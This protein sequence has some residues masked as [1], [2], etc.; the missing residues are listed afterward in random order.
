M[1]G[2]GCLVQAVEVCGGRLELVDFLVEKC[3]RYLWWGIPAVVRV[4]GEA[5][6]VLKGD[7]LGSSWE[8]FGVV[9]WSEEVGILE[10]VELG[11]CGGCRVFLGGFWVAD[12]CGIGGLKCWKFG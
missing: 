10:D 4:R 1:K 6:V 5:W 8:D 12:G 7:V 3:C 9:W 11:C 2:S